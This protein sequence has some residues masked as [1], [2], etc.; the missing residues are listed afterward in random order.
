MIFFKAV[1]ALTFLYAPICQAEKIRIAVAAN[2]NAPMKE[3]AELFKLETGHE[4]AIIS[5]SSGKLYEQIKNGAPF[6][7]FFSA[8]Q[9][10]PQKLIADKMTV[11]NKA[12]TYT[13]GKLALYSKKHIAPQNIEKTL[14]LGQFNMLAIANPKVAPY[15]LAAE[16]YLTKK[17]CLKAL[18]PKI[19]MAEDIQ[20]TLQFVDTENADLGFVSF[21]QISQRNNA[22]STVWVVPTEMYDKIKQDTVMIKALPFKKATQAFL[23]FILGAKAK[24]VFDKYGYQ[25]PE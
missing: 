22:S 11:D 25:N 23:T 17:K 13:I 5:G 16:Q 18:R 10:F 19:V 20:Q 4:V 3:L 9:K 14:E 12:Y 24:P 2:F 15:G 21:S 1:T 8:D 7:M 6:D